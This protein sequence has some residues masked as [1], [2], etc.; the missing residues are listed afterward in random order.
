MSVVADTHTIIIWYFLNPNKLSPDAANALTAASSNGSS[1]YISAIT[2]I[3]IIY[4]VEKNKIPEIALEKLLNALRDPNTNLEIA[5]IDLIVAQSL[6]KIPR[7]TVA[8]VGDRIIAATA[9]RLDLPLITKDSKIRLLE[10]VKTIWG[11]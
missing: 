3:E 7:T 6:A 8:E 10:N 4:L 5:P 1:I 11:D 9:L 2:I